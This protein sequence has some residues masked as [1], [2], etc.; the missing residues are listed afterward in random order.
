M[1]NLLRWF[2][3]GQRWVFLFLLLHGGV[4]LAVGIGTLVSTMNHLDNGVM[5]EGKVIELRQSEDVVYPT[6]R[7]RVNGDAVEFEGAIG[8]GTGSYEIGQTVNVLY[9]VAQPKNATIR[10]FTDL[11]LFPLIFGGVGVIEYLIAFGMGV[12]GR[13]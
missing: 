13:K 1:N 7:F 10:S 8:T 5:T 11:W 2:A 9:D 3:I 4:F 12:F 6:V